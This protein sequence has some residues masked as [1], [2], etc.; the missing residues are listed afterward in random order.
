MASQALVRLGIPPS[1][2]RE[3]GSGGSDVLTS[4]HEYDNNRM[5]AGIPQDHPGYNILAVDEPV[6]QFHSQLH[7]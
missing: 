1:D 4:S 3:D 5:H 6:L 7:Q 2:K